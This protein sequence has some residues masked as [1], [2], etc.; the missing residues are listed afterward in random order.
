[1]GIPFFKKSAPTTISINNTKTTCKLKTKCTDYISNKEFT[2]QCNNQLVDKIGAHL[3]K[4][5]ITKPCAIIEKTFYLEV[6]IDR[7]TF[8]YFE[9]EFKEVTEEK[10]RERILHALPN[11]IAKV[12]IKL[13]RCNEL[14]DDEVMFKFGANVRHTDNDDKVIEIYKKTSMGHDPKALAIAYK[15]EKALVIDRF[16]LEEAQEP[17]A[18][19]IIA[20]EYIALKTEID[21]FNDSPTPLPIV[22]TPS[23]WNYK[24]EGDELTIFFSDS[25]VEESIEFV[26]KTFEKNMSN[27]DPEAC[28]LHSENYIRDKDDIE[29]Y[30][31]PEF[32]EVDFD[33][34]KIMPSIEANVDDNLADFEDEPAPR[35]TIFALSPQLALQLEYIVCEGGYLNKYGL[36]KVVKD[37]LREQ[38]CDHSGLIEL[39]INKLGAV[40]DKTVI[41]STD[42][43]TLNL[44]RNNKAIFPLSMYTALKTNG[45]SDSLAPYGFSREHASLTLTEETKTLITPIANCNKLPTYILD[46]QSATLLTKE[47]EVPAGS[48]LLVGCFIFKL[49][50]KNI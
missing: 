31:S 47:T 43:E 23:N 24:W 13:S 1:M 28:V 49:V 10:L 16:I 7:N 37:N 46:K 32:E 19:S 35:H 38:N 17:V 26:V 29:D 48:S 4:N 14:E 27:A 15:N 40:I 21:D 11:D 34:N 25:G 33:A 3:D 2:E 9:D 42:N 8:I 44:G 45:E 12:D 6:L 30:S 22:A 36:D 50:C 20:N 18:A 5:K 39:G 41:E